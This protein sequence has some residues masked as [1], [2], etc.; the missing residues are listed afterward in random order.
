MPKNFLT[1]KAY[2]LLAVLGLIFLLLSFYPGLVVIF[3]L[4]LAGVFLFRKSKNE[5]HLEIS[6]PQGMVFS[7]IHGKLVE[8]KKGMIHP[9][10]GGKFWEL[11]FKIPFGGET[12]LYLP[13]EGEIMDMVLSKDNSLKGT[14][15]INYPSLL[16]KSREKVSMGLSF[17]PG[18]LGLAPQFF[19]NS[20]DRGKASAN[21]GFFPLGGRVLLYL[22]GNCEILVKKNSIVSPGENFIAK[23]KT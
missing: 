18:Y 19:V 22:P 9:T 16:I 23:I 20:G 13:L 12:G 21:F 5:Y 6:H 1:W 3:L 15:G 7:P 11:N 10:L 2:F 8:I 14:D 4:Y 17:R